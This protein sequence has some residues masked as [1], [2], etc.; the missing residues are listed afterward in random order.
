M[1]IIFKSGACA[2][3]IMLEKSGKAILELLGKDPDENRGIVTVDQL[4]V[5]IAAL[6]RV[7]GDAK[8]RGS[9]AEAET[10]ESD[11]PVDLA[12]RAV[13][14]LEMFEASLVA[15]APVTWGV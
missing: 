14:V 6:H 5:A 8:G 15:L 11:E 3:L 4:P 1:L 2:D 13:P 7:I 10:D 9:I 12:I